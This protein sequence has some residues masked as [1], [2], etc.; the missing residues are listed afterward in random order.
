MRHGRLLV[1]ALPAMALAVPLIPAQVLLP[2]HYADGL[3][4]GLA[5]VGAVLALARFS[6]VV[7]DPLIGWLSDH[8]PSARLP[9]FLAGRRKPFIALGAVLGGI[10]LLQLFAPAGPVGALYLGL[11]SGLLYL[12]WTLISI[13]YAAWGADLSGDYAERAQLTAWRE[14]FGLV[15]VVL[16]AALPSALQTLGYGIA[17]ALQ[18]VAWVAI[19]A[20]AP[21]ILILLWR[22][23]EPPPLAARR[24]QADGL[25]AGLGNRP[26]RRLL[27]AWLLNGVANGLPA[28]LVPLFVEQRLGLGARELGLL[29]LV[30]FMAGL[31]GLPVWLRLVP[32]LGKHKVWS[33]AMMLSCCAFAGAPL[34]GAGQVWAFAAICLLTGATLGADLALPPAMQAD[35]VDLDRMRSGRDRSGLFFAPWGMATKFSLAASVGIAFPLL[36]WL[37]FAPGQANTAGALFALAAIYAWVPVAFKLGAI[38]LVWHHPLTERRQRAIRRRLERRAGIA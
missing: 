28:A 27:A 30:Y 37:G 5:A 31:G 36:A 14:A 23:P 20:G 4:V 26:F 16:A 29:L 33:I 6:D 24:P 15:G 3:G 34:L 17:T 12:G 32:R 2:S 11:W 9:G 7:T 8:W 21:A 18:A 1:Y 38:A 19:A 10:A 25:R 35:V 13:P 22:L